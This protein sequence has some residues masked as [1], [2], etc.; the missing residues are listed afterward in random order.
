MGYYSSG[1]IPQSLEP[2]L[3]TFLTLRKISSKS[4]D[5]TKN[6]GSTDINHFREIPLQTEL[7]LLLF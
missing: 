5:E 2:T 1:K 6:S 4:A 7:N 3:E